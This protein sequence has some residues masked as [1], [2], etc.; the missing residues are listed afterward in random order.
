LQ[1]KIDFQMD[2]YIGLLTYG[3]TRSTD[4][5]VAVPV[6]SVTMNVTSGQYQGYMFTPSSGSAPAYY[7]LLAKPGVTTQVSNVTAGSASGVGDVTLNVK[8][9]LFGQEGSVGRYAGAIGAQLRF[10]TGD[11]ENYL[12]SGAFGANFYGIVEYRRSIHHGP[13]KG[14]APHVKIGYQWNAQSQVMDIS[15]KP[16]LNLPGGLD[17]AFGSD[18]G[19]H[20]TFS[21]AVDG[22]GH[23]YVN[24]PSVSNSNI[25]LPSASNQATQQVPSSFVLSSTA[26]NTYTTFNFS[27]GFK[28]MLPKTREHFLLYANVLVPVN[29]VGLHSDPVPMVGLAY[30]LK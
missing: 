18:F 1:S 20:R 10:P 6:N 24:A 11:A 16:Y 7:T 12:G 19:L 5:T 17:Y 30:K 26:N 21:I 25:S 27:G 9:M 4:I 13:I 15:K 3:L 8:Q 29:N 2:Q 14:V 23:Q 28:W 22:V